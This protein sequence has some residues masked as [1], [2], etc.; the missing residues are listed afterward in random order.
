VK[1]P[2]GPRPKRLR[3]VNGIRRLVDYRFRGCAV[4]GE[5]VGRRQPPRNRRHVTDTWA[6]VACGT[7][8]TVISV[9]NVRIHRNTMSPNE[10]RM[11]NNRIPELSPRTHLAAPVVIPGLAAVTTT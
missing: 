11:S 8:R 10:V 9:S 7:Y 3:A 2:Q 1:Q 6:R 4:H 5:R